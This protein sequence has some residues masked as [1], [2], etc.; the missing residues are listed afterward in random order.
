VGKLKEKNLGKNYFFC[1]LKV[2]EEESDPEL[3]PGPDQEPD[4]LVRGAD[5]HQNVTDPQHWLVS[6]LRGTGTCTSIVFV[7]ERGVEKRVEGKVQSRR[8]GIHINVTL[9]SA[10]LTFILNQ[11]MIVLYTKRRKL[12][13]SDQPLI[14]KYRTKNLFIFGKQEDV[15]V[16]YETFKNTE[17]L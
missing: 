3:D 10:V 12:R 13:A 8:C 5:P 16:H 7:S 15:F 1:I 4:P 6:M 9:L 17:F 2:S 14:L 11:T